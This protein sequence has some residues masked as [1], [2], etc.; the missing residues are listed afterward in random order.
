MLLCETN[1]LRA[2]NF[3]T[4]AYL[5]RLNRSLP[6]VDISGGADLALGGI[7]N[8]SPLSLC[9]SPLLGCELLGRRACRHAIQEREP[10]DQDAKLEHAWAAGLLRGE[11]CAERLGIPA[12]KAKLALKQSYAIGG[13]TVLPRLIVG[14]QRST[15]AHTLSIVL[16]PPSD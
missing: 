9:C 15:M 2:W 5:C 6:S 13:L 14:S 11:R 1:H 8:S 10:A 12:P 4:G 16:R 3:R 7:Q